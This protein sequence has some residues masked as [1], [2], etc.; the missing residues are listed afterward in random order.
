MET[1]VSVHPAKSAIAHI[2]AL[3]LRLTQDERIQVN[4]CPRASAEVFCETLSQ[5]YRRV[6]KI[7]IFAYILTTQ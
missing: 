4:L 6:E 2:R 7:V 1:K 3:I 5:M